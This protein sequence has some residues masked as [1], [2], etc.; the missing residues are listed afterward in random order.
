MAEDVRGLGGC[1]RLERGAEP[2]VR[3]LSWLVSQARD[4]LL[5]AYD[6]CLNTPFAKLHREVRPYTMCGNARLRGLFRAVHHVVTQCIPGDVVECGTAHGGSAAFMGLALKQLG[7][8]RTLWVFDTF[9]GLPPPQEMGPD[10]EIAKRYTGLCRGD[11]EEVQELFRRVGIL[12]DCK[13]MK[14]LFQETLPTCGISTIAVL[15][16]D[17]D[18]YESVK[19]CLDHLY[20]RVSAGGVIQVDD[21]GHWPGARKAVEEF[22][23]RRSIDVRL[24]PLDY[25][26]RQFMKP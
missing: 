1:E 6:A 13:L 2:P 12:A 5:D 18:W 4:V 20:D 21:Y 16:L 23:H 26:G 10:Q 14:G 24:R 22:F 3:N 9:A 8:A 25:T 11:L 19:A 15:H 7:A 17:C